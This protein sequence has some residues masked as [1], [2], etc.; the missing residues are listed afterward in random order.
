MGSNPTGPTTRNLAPF[1]GIIVGV[2]AFAKGLAYAAG[3]LA[4]VGLSWAQK[5]SPLPKFKV[6]KPDAEWKRLLTPSAYQILRHADTERPFTGKYW[7]NH[8]KGL[9]YCAGCNQ[10]LFSSET[11]FESGTGWPSFWK[12]ATKTSI[13]EHADNTLGMSRTEVLCARCGGHLG[14]VFDDGPQPTGLRYCMN[15]NA[16]NFKAAKP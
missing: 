16:M 6:V 14:H 8:A 7:D 11:K 1:S 13:I 5:S 12:P 3:C 10:L 15:G 2:K 4:V 9:Y